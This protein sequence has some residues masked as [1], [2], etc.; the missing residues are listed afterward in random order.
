MQTI[1]PEQKSLLIPLDE[2]YNG[3]DKNDFDDG[4]DSV[5]DVMMGTMMLMIVTVVMTVTV[6]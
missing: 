2:T 1:C 6:M 3:D 4:D 5:C